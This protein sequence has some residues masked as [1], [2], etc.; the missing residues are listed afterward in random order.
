MPTAKIAS[1][2]N[3]SVIGQWNIFGEC[4]EIPFNT[5]PTYPKAAVAPA[6]IPPVTRP[7]SPPKI[8]TMV[9]ATRKPP[10]P[11]L[12]E[13]DLD[14]TGLDERI[15]DGIAVDLETV[16]PNDSIE[17]KLAK[18]MFLRMIWDLKPRPAW[19]PVQDL[20]GQAA[21]LCQGEQDRLD[22]LVWMYSLNPDPGLVPFEW[23]CDVLGFDIHMVRRITG[24]SMRTELKQLV[25]LLST[26]V[27]ADHARVCEETLSD[28]VDVSAWKLN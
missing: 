16:D 7:T 20:F 25:N 4:D 11:V 19:T 26:I 23:V 22:A 28:Y 5:P 6:A 1:S 27:G 17:T 24:R 15:D 2:P 12:T 13:Q 14:F 21:T 8:E 18:R 3:P 10:A 9:L